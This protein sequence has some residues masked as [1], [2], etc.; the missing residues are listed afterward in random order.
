M[1][2]YYV[3]EWYNIDTGE[4]FYVGKGTKNRY[5]Q[6]SGRNQFFLD[7]FNSHNCSSRKIY[8]NLSEEEAYCMERKII[9]FYR[10]NSTFR[11]TN[12]CDGGEGH[13]FPSGNDNPKF[14]K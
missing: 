9:K 14:G 4:I 1:K 11:L 8:T 5:C 12:I 2:K 13:P 6:I 3:Y 7:Y 10:E